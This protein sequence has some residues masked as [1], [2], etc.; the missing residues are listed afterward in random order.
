MKSKFD[1][2][3]DFF[4]EY[5]LMILGVV[6]III[7][8]VGMSLNIS[9]T[10]MYNRQEARAKSKIIPLKAKLKKI[11]KKDA[12]D[13]SKK[14]KTDGINATAIG[15]KLVSAQNDVVSFYLKRGEITKDDRDKLSNAGAIITEIT[16]ITPSVQN[17][18]L[19]NTQWTLKL[20]TVVTY[21]DITMP[22]L[23]TMV[24]RKGDMMGL[25]T[26]RYDSTNNQ[27]TDVVVQYTNA[28]TK[29]FQNITTNN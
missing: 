8:G 23:F 25:V 12:N 14:V 9:S 22:I 18:W 19:R 6:F 4:V 1:A 11:N 26:A 24:N 3:I 10:K 5:W 13:V 20:N 29:D 2:F 7:M 15:N 16:G 28:G 17:M 27:I 21:S